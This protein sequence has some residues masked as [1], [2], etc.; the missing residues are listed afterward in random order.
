MEPI[1]LSFLLTGLF[2]ILTVP[3]LYVICNTS[4]NKKMNIYQK[5]EN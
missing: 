5:L 3:R 2:C 4:S 1:I